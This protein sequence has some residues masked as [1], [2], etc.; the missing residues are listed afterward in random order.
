MRTL[1]ALSFA[2][3]AASVLAL[4]SCGGGDSSGPALRGPSAFV[5][6]GTPIYLE[7][8]LRPEGDQKTNAKALLSEL[9][10]VPL[11]GS[12]VSPED[13]ADQAVKQFDAAVGADV[14]Y[15][16]D[17][18]PWLG[19]KAGLA[20]TG[21][22]SASVGAPAT[23]VPPTY[24]LAVETTDDETARDSLAKIVEGDGSTQK[25]YD[26]VSYYESANGL[27]DTGVFDGMLV[28]ANG[29]NFENAVD[30]EHGGD[31]LGASDDFQG[32]FAPLGEDGLGSAYVDFGSV[33]DLAGDAGT[34][35][36]AG[37]EE[38][39]GIAPELFD[40]PLGA[41]LI[42]G[43]GSIALD[44]SLPQPSEDRLDLSSTN[45]L[46]DAP[47]DS[48]GAVGL[49]GTGGLFET[50]VARFE[51]TG[52]E[53]DDPTLRSGAIDDA[54]QRQFGIS[55]DEVAGAFGDGIAYATG[56]L[57]SSGGAQIDV[58]DDSATGVPAKLLD[59][60]K[61]AYGSNPDA[62]IGPPNDPSAT[63][64]F[65][66][67]LDGSATDFEVGSG[68]VTAA[69]A[70]DPSELVAPGEARL[71][72][73]DGFTAAVAALGDDYPAVAYANLGPILDSIVGSFS[74]S[75][76]VLGSTPPDQVIVQFIASKLNSAAAGTRTEGDRLV[77]RSV[78]V[79][80]N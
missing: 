5:P 35:D 11:L 52:E 69:V 64:G 45:N 41:K 6:P 70:D 26:G 60:L 36:A 3:L 20:I 75:G 34:A 33:A 72:D 50:L 12:Q 30:A 7:A 16:A 22:P 62:T 76:A 37:I 10:D 51:K 9:G 25:E 48:Y 74:L 49:A 77:L 58:S 68:K 65:S 29:G 42:A 1:K 66:S 44:L 19:A 4:A 67:E 53:V 56:D 31:S 57:G 24:V 59:G 32:A 17:V 46:G 28:F 27:Y 43:D 15:A 61:K 23:T 39:R 78:V 47:S 63:A 8:T 14:D 79:L 21:F 55:A 73:E 40:A 54:L 18:E 71:G 2:L 13:L 80:G 38:A